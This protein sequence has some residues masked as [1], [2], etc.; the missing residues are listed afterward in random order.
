[1][2]GA[3]ADDLARW[4]GGEPLAA[5]PA[6]WLRR[7]WRRARARP[8]VRV[9]ATLLALVGVVLTV[10]PPRPEPETSPPAWREPIEF[11]TPDGLRAGS[12]WVLGQGKIGQPEKGS[13]HLESKDLNLLFLGGH[14][15]GKRY[16]F[17]VE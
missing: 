12:R 8:A 11:L 2:A 9:G 15:P 7:T 14:P 4:T 3:L 13:V 5:R 1:T 16:H 17:W 6:S 10:A